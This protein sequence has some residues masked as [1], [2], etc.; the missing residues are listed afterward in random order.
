MRPPLYQLSLSQWENICSGRHQ[1]S[2]TRREW[3]ELSRCRGCE[4]CR[5]WKFQGGNSH[6]FFCHAKQDQPSLGTISELVLMKR[7]NRNLCHFV[8]ED[9]VFICY[10]L[11]SCHFMAKIKFSRPPIIF[12]FPPSWNLINRRERVD[13]YY[14]Y[15]V[16]T[17]LEK[18]LL[19]EK[20]YLKVVNIH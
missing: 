7:C 17:R 8:R 16:H 4:C 15:Y 20:N 10:I 3:C 13:N 6:S 11:S 2:F 19:F 18:N 5:L 9:F 12:L 1:S 14:N